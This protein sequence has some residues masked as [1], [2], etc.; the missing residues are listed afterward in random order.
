MHLCI[1]KGRALISG[2]RFAFYV[3]YKGCFAACLGAEQTVKGCLA[4]GVKALLLLLVVS[5]GL[6]VFTHPGRTAFSSIGT[7]TEVLPSAPI[8]PLR[9]FTGKPV[10]SRVSYRMAK[11]EITAEIYRPFGTGRHAAVVFYIGASP[12]WNNPDLVRVVSALARDGIVVL[13]PRSKVLAS[14]RIDT[15]GKDEVIASLNYLRSQPYVKPERIGIIGISVGGSLATLAAEA[16]RISGQ[17]KLLVLLGSYY[18]AADLLSAVTTRELNVNG[19][20]IKWNPEPVTLEVFHNTLEP[21][22]PKADRKPLT[23]LF[24][25]RTRKIPPNLTPQGRAVARMLVNRDPNRSQILMRNLPRKVLNVLM[26]ISPSSHINQL[27][28]R[29]FLMHDRHDDVIPFTE[30]VHFYRAATST[31]ERSI[32]L[33]NIF[34]HVEPTSR[35]LPAEAEDLPKLYIEIYDVLLQLT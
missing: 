9:W 33:L 30:S 14:Y 2:R 34:S 5:V 11:S 25:Q 17:V 7:L 4:R 10:T 28:T 13:V 24:Y 26:E 16:P 29:L 23:P 18:N 27:H 6:G 8:H 20:W 12:A 1:A 22:L 21:L 31:R 3:L 15:K 19:R 35:D 32:R